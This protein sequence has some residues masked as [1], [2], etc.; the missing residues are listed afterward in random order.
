[1]IISKSDYLPSATISGSKSHENT[2]KITNQSGGDASIKDVDPLTT[3][4]KIEQ[5]L[6]DMGRDAEYQ[7]NK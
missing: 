3:S 4:I 2:N 1:M 5:T 6:F 7:K